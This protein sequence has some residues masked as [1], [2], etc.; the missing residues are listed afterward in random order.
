MW[1][2]EN[3]KNDE[4]SKIRWEL[5]PYMRGKCLDIGCGPYKVFPHFVGVDNGDHWG[6]FDNVRVDDAKDLSQFGSEAWDVAYSSHLLEHFPY[7]DVPNVL[8][9]WMRVTKVGGYLILYL[10]DEKQYPKVGDKYANQDHKW[11]VSYDKVISAMEKSDCGW[12]LIDYQVRSEADE[13]SLFFVFKKLQSKKRKF[14]WKNPKP[15]KT[16]AVVRYGA[17]GDNIQMSSLLPSLKEQGYHVT[18]Y[19][20]SGLGYDV[21]KHDPHVDRFIVQERDAVPPQF[22]LE[23]LEYTKKKYD[24]WIDLCETIEGTL[25]AAPK[26][27]SWYWPNEARAVMMDR[28][29]LEW[30]HQVAQVPPPYRPKFYSTDEEKAWANREKYQGRNVLWS[31]AGSSGH[32]VWPHIDDIIHRLLA[33][34]PDVHIWLVGDESCKL[35]EQGWG[36]FDDEKEDL[37]EVNPR[38]HLRAGKWT[39][40]QSM[41]FAEVADLIIGTETGLLNAAGSME[42]PKIVNLSHSSPEMLT[43]HWL[44]V[45]VLEQPEGVGCPKKWKK[46]GGACRQLHGSGG[47]DPWADCP[48]HEDTGTALCQFHITEESMWDSVQQV[49]GVAPAL[50]KRAA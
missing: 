44:N 6:H 8:N 39:I 1:S 11:D 23:F 28:N 48:K 50:L 22:L 36:K 37:V 20:Q 34:Y 14:S 13:Y 47:T 17:Q 40:R 24:K 31:L 4:S 35:L 41:S 5:V 25:L 33:A 26:R 49:L 30:I 7:K 45:T 43:K 16:A 10:P 21:I 46:N 29:Y 12:D 19:C 9:E 18:V 27:A 2:L 42:V 38:V 3:S 32:K 15:L